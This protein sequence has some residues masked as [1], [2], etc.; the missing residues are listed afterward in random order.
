MNIIVQKYGGSSL[1][2]KSALK[3][4]C[5]RINYYL[6]NKDAKLVVV[7]SAQGK[8]TDNLIKLSK[9][10]TKIQDK[11]SL[12][13]LLA[14]GEMRSA[15]LL[16][17]MLN[18]QNIKSSPLAGWQAGILTDFTYGEAKIID[19]YKENILNALKDNSVVIVTGFQGVTKLGDITTLGRGGSDLSAT[20]LA[21]K[22]NA[23]SCE[24][25]SDIDGVFST[26]PK[27]L[28]N[29][30]LIKKI[31]YDEMIEASSAGA[32]VM[33][34]RSVMVA[35]KF[36][37]PLKIKNSKSNYDSSNETII[38]NISSDESI[39]KSKIKMITKK[40][41]LTEISIIGEMMLSNID[42]TKDIYQIAKKLNSKI[43]MITFSEFAIHIITDTKNSEEFLKAL[44]NKLIAET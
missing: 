44:H 3:N 7:V 36:S 6:K 29:A 13:F 10:Y 25:Y 12:D 23:I 31:S 39:E 40:D 38:E 2:N 42:I 19:I 4:I 41:E 16:S 24:I 5:K 26:D 27:I 8:T 1:S 35:K 15:A 32:K 11:K 37:I 17:M 30:S 21:S 9:Y 18:E 33:H 22:L 28:C 34:N 43:Y 14:T 20:A